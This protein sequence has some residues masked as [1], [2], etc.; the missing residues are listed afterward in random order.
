MTRWIAVH[1]AISIGLIA[2]VWMVYAHNCRKKGADGDEE[3]TFSPVV[4]MRLLVMPV[5]V[6]L[7]LFLLLLAAHDTESDAMPLAVFLDSSVQVGQT[8]SLDASVG[9]VWDA[10][11]QL[12]LALTVGD[13]MWLSFIFALAPLLTV[14]VAA[15]LFRVPKFWLTMLFTRKEICIFSDLNERAMIYAKALKR[16]RVGANGQLVRQRPYIVFCSDGNADTADTTDVLGQS[17]VLKKNICD[18]YLP[19]RALRRVHFYL[20]T[21]DENIIIEQASELQQKYMKRGCRIYCVSAGDLNEDAVDQMNEMA[22][23]GRD[24]STDAETAMDAQEPNAGEMPKGADVIIFDESGRIVPGNENYVQDVQTSFVE[25]IDETARVVYQNL[26]DGPLFNGE[27]LET[28]FGD[29]DSEERTLRILVLG[30]GS[31]GE[32]FARTMLWYCQLPGIGVEVTVADKESDKVIRG[33]ILQKNGQFEALLDSIGYGALARLN[34]KGEKDLRTSDLEELLEGGTYHK[35]IIATGDDNQNYQLALRIR[36]Y[37]LRTA[38]AWGCPD[39]R[40]VIWDDTMTRL[41]GGEGYVTLGGASIPRGEKLYTDYNLLI[42][43]VEKPR[44]N[45]A[46]RVGLMG[47]MSS[48]MNMSQALQYDALRYHAFYCVK[49]SDGLEA[50]IARLAH[51]GKGIEIAKEHYYS[52]F[53]CRESDKRSNWAV[54]VHGKLKQAWRGSAL[55]RGDEGELNRALAE[56][57]HIRWCV[58]K[59]LEGDSPVPE[60]LLD[61]YYTDNPKGRDGD[62]VRGYHVNLRSYESLKTLAQQDKDRWEQAYRNNI[63]LIQFTAALEADREAPQQPEDT[64]TDEAVFEGE[65]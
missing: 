58:F 46:C 23:S 29:P 6:S 55:A 57:E 15:S 26:Y 10:A 33:R 44:Y 48:T 63:E 12:D 7:F 42:Q 22:N 18:L 54:V 41:I 56:N 1:A 34:V 13:R 21:D 49:D 20:V 52:F 5:V 37:Y 47:S 43:N 11:E 2:A 25:I 14:G 19:A 30:A 35:I 31:V 60:E 4:L 65:G 39:I 45:E 36:R 27:F 38:P 28:V 61:K 3:S 53:S 51:S 32:E 9:D 24:E 40:A 8:F 62:P 59:L 50:A 17:L 64:R 16:E